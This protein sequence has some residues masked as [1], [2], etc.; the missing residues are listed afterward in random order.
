MLRQHAAHPGGPRHRHGPDVIQRAPGEGEDFPLRGGPHLH[1]DF[2]RHDE[3]RLLLCR[4]LVV[5]RDYGRDGGA[6]AL[7]PRAL[8]QCSHAG[9]PQP[10]GGLLGVLLRR[11][12]RGGLLPRQ[13]AE[14]GR[15]PHGLGAALRARPRVLPHKEHCAHAV[16]PRACRAVPRL[17]APARARRRQG[18]R[19]VRVLRA[20]A[21]RGLL[22]CRQRRAV[23]HGVPGLDGGRVQ[24]AHQLHP[25]HAVLRD[26]TEEGVVT[27]GIGRWF[28]GR[29]ARGQLCIRVGQGEREAHARQAPARC[30]GRGAGRQPLGL[31]KH[32]GHPLSPGQGALRSGRPPHCADFGGGDL[33]S[34][35]ADH[36]QHR[37]GGPSL[38]LQAL[39]P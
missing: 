11:R 18:P 4:A 2:R 5:L 23:F 37:E 9:W 38:L 13:P 12:C 20:P 26:G 33:L 21:A 27:G 6:G 35:H 3:H 29:P 15:L 22:L 36:G 10:A 14:R 17:H 7:P 39:I 1:H 32:G 28:A 30:G 19:R 31:G 16:L 34:R 25:P 8:C 24:W